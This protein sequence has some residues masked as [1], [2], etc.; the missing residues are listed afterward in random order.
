MKLGY[1]ETEIC[2]VVICGITPGNVARVYL[3]GRKDLTVKKLLATLKSYFCEKNVTTVYNQ[4]TRAVQG[5]EEKDTP[6]TFAIQMFALRDQVLELSKQPGAH[7]YSRKLVQAE[8]QK[9]IYAGLREEG[10][11][12][13]LKE[14][15]IRT[16]N[17]NDGDLLEEISQAMSSLEEHELRIQDAGVR[18]KAGGGKVHVSYVGVDHDSTDE[19]RPRSNNRNKGNK[20]QKKEGTKTVTKEDQGNVNAST[21][22]TRDGTSPGMPNMEPFLAQMSVLLGAQLQ[23]AMGPLKS[24]VN[25]LMGFKREYEKAT[26][27]GHSARG[28]PNPPLNVPNKF[29]D[30]KANAFNIK[31]ANPGDTAAPSPAGGLG[32]GADGFNSK[33]QAFQGVNNPGY[34]ATAGTGPHPLMGKLSFEEFMRQA[35]D[36]NTKKPPKKC[37][38]CVKYGTPYCNHCYI[39]FTTEHRFFECP[40]RGDPSFVPPLV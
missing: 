23:S 15:L 32:W 4:M 26:N 9:S 7:Q 37:K 3:E 8:M 21:G 33:T 11:R 20:T 35:M 24:Q 10:I 6:I 28:K 36:Q 30:P 12:R 17:V 5:T 27:S 22:T 13:D 29:L 18:R 19:E 39:C 2:N 16:T 38:K 31:I 40:H 34:G 25:E 1:P 14:T